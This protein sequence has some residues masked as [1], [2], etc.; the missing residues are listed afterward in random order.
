[1]TDSPIG[2][3]RFTFDFDRMSVARL[4]DGFSV[5]GTVVA[6]NINVGDPVIVSSRGG[7]FGGKLRGIELS[8]GRTAP[9]AAKGQEVRL[10][11]SGI[12]FMDTFGLCS[13]GKDC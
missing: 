2:A 1:M 11:V 4:P 5:N 12:Q 8:A 13:I 7:A 3:E 10:L 6:G 9:S